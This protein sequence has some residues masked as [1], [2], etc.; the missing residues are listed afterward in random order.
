MVQNTPSEYKSSAIRLL[1]FLV[2]TRRPLTLPEAVEVVATEINQEPRGFDVKCRLFQAADILQ[3]CP[4]L[5]IIAEATNYTE[6]V[7]EL[8][9]A[10]FSVKEYLL[11]QAQ[12]NLENASIAISKTFLTYLTD[13]RGSHS[14]IIRDFPMAKYAAKSWMDYAVS[15]ETSEEIVRITDVNAHGGVY[16]NALQ[17]ASLWGHLEI[18]QLLLD[19]GAGIN[20]QGG[21]YGNTLQAALSNGNLEVVQLLLENK[22]DITVADNDGCPPVYAASFNGHVEVVKLLLENE[23]DI[24]VADNDGWTPVIAASLNGHAEVVTLLL[25]VPHIDAS[26]PDDL[27]RTALFLASRHGQ[28]QAARVLLSEG[29]VNPDVRD[30]MGSTA[31]FAAVANG[32]LHV[33]KLLIASGAAVEMQ[34]GVGRSLIWWALRADNTELIQLLVEH[35]ETVGTWI[36]ADHIPNDLVSTPFDHEAPWCDACVS[37]ASTAP[38]EPEICLSQSIMYFQLILPRGFSLDFAAHSLNMTNLVTHR[39]HPDSRQDVVA[40]QKPHEVGKFFY[41]A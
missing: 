19:K 16:G 22:A 35:D 31:L 21:R 12:F 24:T 1:Q 26:K 23:A 3:Y 7:E 20:A 25:A 10:H 4:N 17:A 40:V 28:Y 9:L 15:A 32:H 11:E 34:A 14:T 18:M 41:A 13:I 27:G 37:T 6:T 8:H 36:P 30:W 39:Q 5:V 29:R 33:A 2:H 38:L